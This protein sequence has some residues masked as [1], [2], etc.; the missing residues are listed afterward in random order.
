MVKIGVTTGKDDSPRLELI[1]LDADDWDYIISFRRRNFVL[2]FRYEKNSE[3]TQYT[4]MKK[5][6][7]KVSSTRKKITNVVKVGEDVEFTAPEL[8]PADTL[9]P[10]GFFYATYN[11]EL[12][13]LS[14]CEEDSLTRF[15]LVLEKNKSYTSTNPAQLMPPSHD[16]VPGDT[17]GGDTLGGDTLPGDTLGEPLTKWLK[18]HHAFKEDTLDNRATFYYGAMR[19]D[20]DTIVGNDT[21]G[22]TLQCIYD[23]NKSDFLVPLA[24]LGLGEDDNADEFT[25]QDIVATYDG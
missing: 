17:L 2:W 25:I 15:K 14:P 19:N 10:Y 7:L 13:S 18:T 11:V 8:P 21:T 20:T 5:I 16:S 3:G 9:D 6:V 12:D 24:G 4:K 22:G 1:E 23:P